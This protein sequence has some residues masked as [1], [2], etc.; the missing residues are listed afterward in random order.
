MLLWQS[1][2]VF[3][4]IS[5]PK[6]KLAFVSEF[7]VREKSVLNLFCLCSGH[8]LIAVNY[9]VIKKC[10]AT[11]SCKCRVYF[12]HAQ[13]MQNASRIFVAT[14]YPFSK[15]VHNPYHKNH[16]DNCL[17]RLTSLSPGDSFWLD[18][19][20]A[21]MINLIWL[22][23]LRKYLFTKVA[24]NHKKLTRWLSLFMT[25]W[26]AAAG[27]PGNRNSQGCQSTI[28]TFS[29]TLLYTEIHSQLFHQK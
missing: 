15:L 6:V 25:Q 3:F 28:N 18:W 29:K 21:Q 12:P 10:F 2:P 20:E 14:F 11:H 13:F 27:V 9:S 23:W 8:I 16:L 1:Q 26:N 4:F 7:P 17:F 5:W 22:H 19:F 24:Q